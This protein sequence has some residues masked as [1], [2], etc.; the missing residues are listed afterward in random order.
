MGSLIDDKSVFW[1][2]V[3]TDGVAAHNENDFGFFAAYWFLR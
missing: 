1:D 2:V 3:R